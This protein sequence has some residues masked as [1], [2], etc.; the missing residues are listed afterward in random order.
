MMV[1]IDAY[2]RGVFSIKCYSARRLCSCM[3]QHFGRTLAWSLIYLLHLLV[4]FY[5]SY[6]SATGFVLA[7]NYFAEEPQAVLVR[8]DCAGQIHFYSWTPGIQFERLK[9]H[10]FPGY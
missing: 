4:A 7:V 2:C 1:R 9:Q 6:F 3:F 5:V 8:A 10:R